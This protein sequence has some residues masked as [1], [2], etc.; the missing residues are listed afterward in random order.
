METHLTRKEIRR[1]VLAIMGDSTDELLTKNKKNQLNA[2]IDAA[3]QEV[4]A[5][6]NWYCQ[7]RKASIR[8]DAG[9]DFISYYDLEKAYWLAT[10]YPSDY[11]PLTYNT[12]ADTWDTVVTPTIYP[13]GPAG[14]IDVAGWNDT[15][16]QWIVLSDRV[17]SLAVDPERLIAGP[18]EEQLIATEEGASP[19]EIAAR[20][21]SREDKR[22]SA[23]DIPLYFEREHN[24]IR[25]TPVADI[26]YVLR[27][28]YKVFP[29]WAYHNQTLTAEQTDNME[30]AVD[31]L[32]IVY[33]TAA[34]LS[35]HKGDK[36]VAEMFEAKA[37]ARMRDVR[38]AMNTKGSYRI[39]KMVAFDD[40][41]DIAVGPRY[42]LRAR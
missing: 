6:A 18:A 8:L 31:G 41:A 1:Q 7:E 15:A 23:R 32:S 20:V 27:I 16:S 39:D 22:D 2:M 4:A 38:G 28:K 30:S 37:L 3:S 24:G 35:A 5:F 26:A 40:D 10:T 33:K 12:S 17:A 19:S 14:I 11:R 42:D 34:M 25:I 36:Y 21:Q 13:V 29:T 9:E